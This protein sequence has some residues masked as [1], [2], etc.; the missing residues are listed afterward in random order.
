MRKPVKKIPIL[1][2]LTVSA[3][4]V[5]AT[6]AAAAEEPAS[7]KGTVA[8]AKERMATDAPKVLTRPEGSPDFTQQAV[9]CFGDPRGDTLPGPYSR[10]DITAFCGVNDGS[11]VGLSAQLVEG[12]N[13]NTDPAWD[14]VTGLLF[15]V[16]VSS[17]GEPDFEVAYTA[18]GA[19]VTDS[20]GSERCSAEQSFTSSTYDVS[21]PSSC[22]GSP[23]SFSFDAFMAYDS[24]P[25]D[26]DAPVYG[27]VTDVAGPVRAE[28]APAPAPEPAPQRSTGRLAGADR[29]STAVAI[30]QNVFSGGAPIVFLARADSFADALAGGTLSRGPILLVP[31][32]GSVPAVVLAEVR[33]LG[34]SEVVALGGPGAVCDSVLQQVADA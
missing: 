18:Y 1:V 17:S 32:C 23:A 33:R 21:F 12:S 3:A 31:Q 5:L 20:A 2:A 16:Y 19:S 8:E 6:N 11:T 15:D 28:S 9:S 34:A 25:Y 26:P 4:A 14:G 30:S 22:I 24:N 10:A 29:F 7:S 27:D 13:P